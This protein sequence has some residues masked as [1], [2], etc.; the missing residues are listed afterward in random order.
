MAKQQKTNWFA[1]WVTGGVVVALV[2]VGA[3][4][5][6]M[7]AAATAPAPRPASSGI[8]QESG[9]IVVGAGSNE[10]DV[11]FD[12]FCSHCQEFEARAG[13]AITD[14]I[15]D[16]SITLNLHPVA[17]AGLNAASGTDF[18]KR[19]SNAVYCVADA[20]PEAAYPFFQSVFASY[21]SG[22]GL[23]DEQLVDFAKKAGAPDAVA[24]CIAD[25]TWD[26]LVTEQT[27]GLP[28]NPADGQRGTPTLVINGEYV[29]VTSDP[30]ADITANL[31]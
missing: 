15:A 20:E 10:V 13:E 2:A 11:Y 24:D 26:D 4:V 23:T 12:F 14:G 29:P 7:N 30:V 5:V 19:A 8:D 9:A 28:A 18:S 16:G 27:N 21:P 3:L 25:R 6:W 22:S 1:V 17:L 31:K